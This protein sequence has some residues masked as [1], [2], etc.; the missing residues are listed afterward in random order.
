M[1]VHQAVGMAEP[2]ISFINMLDCV[3]EV[4]PVLVIFENSLL[5]IAAGGDVI[6]GTSVFYT[7]RAGHKRNLA[8]NK[9]NVKLKDLTL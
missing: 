6:N 1:I 9:E 2:V 5:F 4:D 7:E 8:N 3:Q